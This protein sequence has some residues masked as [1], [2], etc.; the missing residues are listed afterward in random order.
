MLMADNLNDKSPK[1]NKNFFFPLGWPTDLHS[2]SSPALQDICVNA[3]WNSSHGRTCSQ[4]VYKTEERSL[5]S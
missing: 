5:T 2:G 1:V 3:R 4:V